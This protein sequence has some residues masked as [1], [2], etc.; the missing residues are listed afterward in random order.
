ML[1]MSKNSFMKVH[2]V[3]QALLRHQA[4]RN[5]LRIYQKDNN[6]GTW[7]INNVES[8]QSM[9]RFQGKYY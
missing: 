1:W 9:K 2:I 6:F 3:L 4:Y 7:K 8:L 5:D